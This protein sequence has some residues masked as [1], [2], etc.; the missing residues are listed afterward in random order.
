MSA[1]PEYE[2]AELQRET[3]IGGAGTSVARDIPRIDLSDYANRKEAIADALWQAATQVGFF[4][5]FNHGIPEE[6]IDAAFAVAGEFFDLPMAEKAR[7]ARR[8]GS[9][10]GWEYRAQV[11]PSTG[12][13]DNKES[14]QI[15]LPDMAGL[16]PTATELPGFQ[17]R[18]CRFERQ[19]WELGMKIL[20]CFAIRLGFDS[21]FFTHNHDPASPYYQSTLR[22]IHYMSMENATDADFDLWRAGAHSDFDCL[23][24]LHQRPG[25]GGLQVC[26]GMEADAPAWTD[27]PPLRGAVTCNI[28]DMLM[29]WSDDRLRSTLHRVRMPRRDEYLGPRLSLPFFCQANR[30]AVIQGPLK[31]YAP[32]TARDYLDERIRA[33]YTPRP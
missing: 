12:T 23:T 6:D 22:L 11:R 20:S 4:Q 33:N 10:A 3:R 30:D 26:P 9:N 15:T 28:G 2:L 32:I 5:V 17:A 31:K 8:P 16:W 13:P 24:L 14:Y 19:N 29:R 18:M 7:H 25:Q 21:D 27:V 1:F